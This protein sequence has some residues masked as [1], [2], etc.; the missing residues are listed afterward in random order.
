MTVLYKMQ[1]CSK[2]QFQSKILNGKVILILITIG[3]ISIS[4]QV[5]GDDEIGT[6]VKEDS[7][8]FEVGETEDV[9]VKHVIKSGTWSE[10]NPR[11][12]QILSG[13]H[14][15][16]MVIDEDGDRM[17]FS[18]KETSQKMKFAQLNQKAAGLDLIVTYDLKEFME[19]NNGMW[20]KHFL[21]SVDVM[22]L[23]EDDI[24]LIFANERPVD[25][26][27]AKGI[28]CVGCQLM[29][30][31]FDDSSFMYTVDLYDKD[32]DKLSIDILSN[33]KISDV[34]FRNE[35]KLLNFNVDNKEQVIVLKIPLELILNPY[36]VYFTDKDD[37]DLDQVDKI[38]KSEYFQDEEFVKISF[39][40]TEGG[41]VSVLGATPEQ[42]QKI[43]EKN[44]NRK[45][46]EIELNFKEEMRGTA[47]PFSEIGK[48]N[49]LEKNDEER[50]SFE[51]ELVKKQEVKEAD[52]VM[53]FVIL[54]IIAVIIIGIIIK[55]KKN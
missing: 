20:G 36:E 33:G 51:D 35:L 27:D 25:V 13:E 16:L 23:F 7:I 5:F 41:T 44:E 37:A 10:N 32:D 53:I 24:E 50:L 55:M 39:K 48:E 11:F 6:V 4:P 12:L 38:R 40:T 1:K 18:Y 19:K 42:H 47:L 45:A 9:R 14:S 22:I 21:F 43:L 2:F 26:T 15:N 34:Q 8:V 49:V 52:N 31:Y 17:S 3:L 30:E 54:G 28:N 29:V 46:A